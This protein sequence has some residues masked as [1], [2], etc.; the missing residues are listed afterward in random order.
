MN[1]KKIL[2]YAFLLYCVSCTK[3]KRNIVRVVKPT[4]KPTISK[5]SSI[6]WTGEIEFSQPHVYRKLLKGHRRCEPCTWLNEGVYD[7]KN[8]DNKA[9][10]T[11]TFKQK[12]FPSEVT[13]RLQPHRSGKFSSIFQVRAGACN[14][15]GNPLEP[16]VLTGTAK[17]YNN[18]EGF[19]VRFNKSVHNIQYYVSYIH[20]RSSRSTPL[21]DN[22]LKTRM[23]YGSTPSEADEI[24]DVRFQNEH[25]TKDNDTSTTFR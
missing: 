11:L 23:Y 9:D 15:I 19:V 25:E 18:F 5:T 7:C 13:L 12:K 24:G 6:I 21:K 17:S 2:C 1:I 20:I 16:I 14:Y 8:Y 22:T 4:H 3:H 10:I